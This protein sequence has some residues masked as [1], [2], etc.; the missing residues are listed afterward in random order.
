ML[1]AAIN[2]SKA[3]TL[4]V[5]FQKMQLSELVILGFTKQFNDGFSCIWVL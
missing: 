4:C 3:K 5:G 1:A 2:T